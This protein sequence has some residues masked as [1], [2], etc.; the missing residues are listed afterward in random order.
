[1]DHIQHL[2]IQRQLSLY[3]QNSRRPTARK[4]CFARFSPELHSRIA[5]KSVPWRIRRRVGAFKLIRRN[6]D[7]GT[8]TYT[9]MS[10]QE[11]QK[12]KINKLNR[13]SIK[14]TR[15]ALLR[16]KL[17]RKMNQKLQ[18]LRATARNYENSLEKYE[19]F[20]SQLEMEE[21]RYLDL[22]NNL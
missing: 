12:V 19:R 11:Y 6:L 14:I 20:S 21:T 16:N 4:T 13:Q 18:K 15:M 8:Y 2:N 3:R 1:M 10:M 9:W 17:R 22:R 5:R 7:L